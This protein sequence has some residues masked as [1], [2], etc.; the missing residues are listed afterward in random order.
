[1]S[2]HIS[3][4]VVSKM[5]LSLISNSKLLTRPARITIPYNEI[6]ESEKD[7]EGNYILNLRYPLENQKRKCHWYLHRKIR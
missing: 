5:G 3:E 7:E 2:I 6:L 4:G 1:M